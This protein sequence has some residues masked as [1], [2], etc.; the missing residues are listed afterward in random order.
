[1]LVSFAIEWLE[2]FGTQLPGFFEH[3]D[4]E[5][6]VDVLAEESRISASKSKTY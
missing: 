1:M 3:C 5:F 6:R 2:T 4:R